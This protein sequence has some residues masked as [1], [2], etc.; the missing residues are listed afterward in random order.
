LCVAGPNGSG[1]STVTRSLPIFGTYINA[2]ELKA[3]YNLSDLDAAEQ[4]DRLRDKLLN[5]KDDFS[6]ET[7]LST[8]RNMKLL[9][10][11]KEIGYEVQC[12]YVLTCDVNINVKRVKARF[13]QGGH[14]VPE[15]KIRSRYKR[16]LKLVPEL[17]DICDTI[18]IYDNS[19]IP[20]LILKKESGRFERFP[21]EFWSD[22][23]IKSLLNI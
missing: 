18:L 12:I 11:A 21:N 1:K 19:K 6:F 13:A 22:T 3:E 7:V 8:E 5:R 15:D 9:K 10:R 23:Q 14:N 16:A 17:I 2:D 20:T 4:A